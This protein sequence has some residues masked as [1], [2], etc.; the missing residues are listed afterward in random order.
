MIKTSIKEKVFSEKI[1][2]NEGVKLERISEATYHRIL[3][4]FESEYKFKN[5]EEMQIGNYYVK[6]DKRISDSFVLFIEEVLREK[7]P[8]ISAIP[9]FMPSK[10]TLSDTEKNEGFT[11]GS[12]DMAVTEMGLRNIEFQ[13]V[14]TYPI[15]AAKMN[16]MVLD[17]I[18]DSNT[19]AFADN[20]NTNW[21]KF[22]EVYNEIF[23]VNEKDQVV[24][25]DREVE[26]QKTKFEFFATKKELNVPIR[27][28]DVK[29]VF[30]NNNSLYYREENSTVKINAFYN[31]V[32]IT[33]ALYQ[34][35]YP[36]D[37]G[38]WKFRFDKKYKDLKY[39]N[40]PIKQFDISKRLCPFIKHEYN[41]NCYELSNTEH[42]FKQKE[43]SYKDFVWKH[44]WGAAG[45]DLILEPNEEVL[46]GLKEETSNYI[47]QEKIA[48]K[49]FKTDDQL[50]KI[51]ELRFMT[52]IHKGQLVIV[53]MARVGRIE[54]TKEGSINYKIHFSDN[55]KKGY[56]FSP[57]IISDNNV[58]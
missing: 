39:I 40:H 31:R 29:D 57:V 42:L 53:P 56:G 25:V 33:E 9:G 54:K 43:L 47:A 44:K 36:E 22:I 23:Q 27:I 11:F 14:A 50:E 34:D 46:D 28:V 20:A 19:F 12:F 45:N 55:N 38:R 7:Y 8:S 2:I 16:T 26:K 17:S 32:L 30:E 51:V 15:S 5:G 58:D 1:N 52:A 49:V 48:Y 4:Y 18:S 24:L 37:L 13:A 41:P 21:D 35:N 6:L 3:K 10:E